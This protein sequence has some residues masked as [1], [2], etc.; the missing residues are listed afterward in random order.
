[1]VALRQQSSSYY[2]ML[3]AHIGVA[4][5]IFGVTMVNGFEEEK[6][7]RMSAGTSNSLAGYDFVLNNIQQV[8]G[9]NYV[10]AQANITVTKDNQLIT[11]MKPEKRKYFSSQML[12]TEAAIHTSFTGDLYISMAEAI[13]NTEWGVKIQFKPFINW[14]W[15]GAFLIA[16]G[17]FFA[18]MDKK[19]RFK[20]NNK[21]L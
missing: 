10:A 19:Y 14:I 9:E 2:G 20:K 17:G 6:D 3:I 12:M 8:Q 4:V 1:M 7:L 13:S 15:G 5:F 16:L 21:P 11:V 18:V